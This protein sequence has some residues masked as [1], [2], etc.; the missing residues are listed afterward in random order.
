MADQA[1][2]ILAPRQQRFVQEYVIDFNG[3]AAARR[4]GYKS[5]TA[6]E[7]AARM[8][9]KSNIRQAVELAKA[10]LGER[11]EITKDW[12]IQEARELVLMAK[13]Q[14]SAIGVARALEFLARLHGYIPEPERRVRLIRQVGDLSEEELMALAASADRTEEEGTR[15]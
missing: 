15:H 9:A 5:T 2:A 1:T 14:K 8:L 11:V 10:A 12:V 6:N 3:A 13:T 7:Q 4:A